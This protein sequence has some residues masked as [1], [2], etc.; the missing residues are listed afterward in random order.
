MKFY[1]KYCKYQS[2]IRC[3]YDKH[4]VTYKHH[5]NKKKNVEKRKNGVEKRKNGV[6]KRKNLENLEI[7]GKYQC[8]CCHFSSF[9]K[10]DYER[11]LNSKRHKDI[12][13]CVKKYIEKDKKLQENFEKMKEILCEKEIIINN[14]QHQVNELTM[15]NELLIEMKDICKKSNKSAL[16]IIINNYNN[17]PNFEA[18]PIHDMSIKEFR[19]YINKGVPKGLVE[20]IR[21]IYVTD[22]PNEERSLWCIDQSRLK[23]L[24]R[25][26][27]K[28][29]VDLMGQTFRN[30]LIPPIRKRII[31]MTQGPKQEYYEF[32]KLA[33][34][35]MKIDNNKYQ[36]KV[37]KEI[38]N[39]FLLEDKK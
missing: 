14:L 19:K 23:Y 33:E 20:L 26:E 12:Y 39:M 3:N 9:N 2:N 1:C 37:M 22:I 16:Q 6:E 4:L 10:T 32:V 34:S 31:D 11:H 24:I 35:V 7:I 30:M 28:W 18:P 38:S 15:K 36:N 27:G 17:A 21:D 29:K 13:Q 25:E 8:N 5:K